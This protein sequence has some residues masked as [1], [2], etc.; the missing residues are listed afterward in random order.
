MS[1]RLLA[2]ML[3]PTLLGALAAVIAG[4]AT[5]SSQWF[6]F[7]IA[8]GLCIPAGLVVVLLQQYLIGTSPYGRVM[9]MAAGT[10]I[11]VAA[12]FGG[13]VVVFLLLKPEAKD[14][15]L[16]FWMWILFAYLA[17]LAIETAMFAKARV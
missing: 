9:A 14:D 4:Q 6:F 2:V 10:A 3:L 17:A 12:C 1:R 11:R 7:G 8:Y 16:A 5:G 13:G 15:K